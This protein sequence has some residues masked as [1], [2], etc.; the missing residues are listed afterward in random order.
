M[1]SASAIR[2]LLGE[3]APTG[4]RLVKP[5][6]T[7]V[8]AFALGAGLL[9]LAGW[10][11]AASAVAGLAVASTFSFL[12][13]S[14]GVQ[15]LAW[16]RTLARY[17]ERIS[18][19]EATL[20]LVGSLRTSLFARALHLPRDRVAELRSS[21]LLGRI[22]VD[23]DAV[24]NLL[25]RS[26]FPIL[27][28]IAALIGAAAMFAIL[29]IALAIVAAAGLV[30]TSAILVGLACHQAGQPARTLVTARADARHT[31]IE[32][33]DGLPE[34]RSFGAEQKAA[35]SATRQLELLGK[36]RGQLT[37]LT[38][39]GQ[40]IGT[41][42]ADLTLLAVIATAAGL[43]G[44]R[45]LPVPAFVAVC[46]VT[47]AVFEP[48][49]GLPGAITAMARARAACARLTELF[50]TAAA[51][52]VAAATP[53]ARTLPYTTQIELEG[54]DIGLPL[55][56]GDTVLLTGV[57]GTGKSTILRAISRQPEHVTLVAQDAYVFDG[58]IRENLQLAD[59]AATEP[60]LWAALAAAALDDTIAAFPTG[61]DTPVGPGG[62]ALS[63]GQ[64]R[65]LSV[66]QG[67]LRHADVLLLDEPT[68]ALDAPTAARLLAGV[69]EFD[70]RAALVIALHDRQSPVLPWTPTARI[71][72]TPAESC[73]TLSQA[74]V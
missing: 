68:E 51:T 22:T 45:A 25:L 21:E 6:A 7:V 3:H 55:K 60:D 62:A 30:L 47:I 73:D 36:S 11:I 15:A 50:P 24:E 4:R 34:L 61:L 57:S 65:R 29:S 17:R 10:F 74:V 49:V 14:A 37:R 19:H 54:H 64:R 26:S 71:E 5:A 58:T 32:T 39:R 41:F 69:R 33:L 20:D 72:L 28:T 63:G 27:A 23:S 16:A 13:P 59:P 8:L 52:T 38:A 44:T 18:T 12:F 9:A 48:V 42:L 40:S 31:L 70:P 46:L 35:A 53:L 56:A 43:T 67:L 1:N 2:E 66:A